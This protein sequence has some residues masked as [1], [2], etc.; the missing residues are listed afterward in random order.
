VPFVPLQTLWNNFTCDLFL[1]IGLGYGAA[2]SGLMDRK[3]RAADE[4][5]LPRRLLAYLASVGFVIGATTLGII[6]W[7]T[8]PHGLVVARTMG[9]TAFCLS[10]VFFAATTKDE[11]RSMF[12]LDTFAD[13]PFLIATGTA[14]VVIVLTT[15]LAPLQRLLETTELDLNQWL[16]CIGAG[17]VVVA[18]S[19]IRKA[20]VHQP[21]D[22]EAGAVAVAATPRP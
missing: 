21:L 14:L 2:A 16:I 11:R 20:V 22:E 1:A 8:D 7:A 3:P 12:N 9:F 19:E 10:H 13:K 6:S 5:V 17:L 4:A 15:T 18:L